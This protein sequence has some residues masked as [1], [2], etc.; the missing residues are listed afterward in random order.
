V[1]ALVSGGYTLREVVPVD[2]F[3]QT[4]DVEVV[5]FLSGPRS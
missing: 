5:A 4:A 2:M 1:K 3:P